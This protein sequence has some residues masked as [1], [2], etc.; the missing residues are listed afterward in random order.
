[1]PERNSSL[2]TWIK[3]FLMEYLPT[4]RN[5]AINMGRLNTRARRWGGW[6]RYA[7]LFRT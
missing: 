1:M 2:G 6:A 3:R 4:E 5:L 7:L